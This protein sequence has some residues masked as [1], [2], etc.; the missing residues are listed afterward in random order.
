[1]RSNLKLRGPKSGLKHGP[2]SSR[3]VHSAPLLAQIPD[4]PR[5]AGLEGV[6]SREIASSEPPIRNPP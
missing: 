3:G 4:L 2:R 5:K 1:M 6:R